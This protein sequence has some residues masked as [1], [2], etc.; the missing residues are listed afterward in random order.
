MFT[1]EK[2]GKKKVSF[3][4]RNSTEF[5]CVCLSQQ[6]VVRGVL[7]THIDIFVS[8]LGPDGANLC[9]S[10]HKSDFCHYFLHFVIRLLSYTMVNEQI[11]SLSWWCKHVKK[12]LGHGEPCL[13][14]SGYCHMP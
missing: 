10:H 1:L 5:L 9:Y 3:S 6:L 12:G 14:R 2:Q 4:V 7:C 11:L 8:I 13:Y